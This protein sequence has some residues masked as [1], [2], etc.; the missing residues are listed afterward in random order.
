M[1]KPYFHAPRKDAHQPAPSPSIPDMKPTGPRRNNRWETKL[2]RFVDVVGAICT[3]IM[4]APLLLAIAA[5]VKISSPGPVLFSQQRVGLNRNRFWLLKFRS[6]YVGSDDS[7]LRDMVSKE[8][9][10]ED[11]SRGG[12]WKLADDHRITPLGSFLRRWSLDELPQLVNVLRGDMS[13]VGPRPCLD[14]EAEMFV[15]EFGERFSVLPGLTGLWQ[16]GGRSTMGTRDML[17]LDVRY[18]RGRTLTGDMSILARTLPAVLRADGA[19]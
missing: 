10:G 2:R 18:V 11:M 19:R 3:L 6:M 7:A 8:M 16:V 1:I 13:L 4:L 9:R 14:W 5:A 17:A 12:S 15:P